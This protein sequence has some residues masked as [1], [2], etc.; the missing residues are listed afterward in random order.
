MDF[1]GIT[2]FS[3]EN[4]SAPDTYFSL[5]S[6]CITVRRFIPSQLESGL[7][8]LA[9]DKTPS[10]EIVFLFE[11]YFDGNLALLLSNDPENADDEKVKLFVRQNRWKRVVERKDAVVERCDQTDDGI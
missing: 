1:T 10:G 2:P 7:I 5:G 3:S 11:N 9:Q 4:V 6:Y 8:R